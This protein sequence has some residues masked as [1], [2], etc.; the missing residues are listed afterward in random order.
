[1]D[2]VADLDDGQVLREPTGAGV[3]AEPLELATQLV[4]MSTDVAD[5]RHAG[6]RPGRARHGQDDSDEAQDS[7]G[8]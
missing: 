7:A 1:V 8:T 4:D 2:E 6:V 3:R 5:D